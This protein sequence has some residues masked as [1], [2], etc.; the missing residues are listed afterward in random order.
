MLADTMLA[1]TKIT[2]REGTYIDVEVNY[3]LI[4]SEM[5]CLTVDIV[6]DN[7]GICIFTQL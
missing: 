5:T 3:D 6:F 1:N 2:L 7:K 4:V